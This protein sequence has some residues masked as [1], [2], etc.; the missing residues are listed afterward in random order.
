MLTLLT[1]ILSTPVSA[2]A[3]GQPV[4][5]T[6]RVRCLEA[7]ASAAD[8]A[9]HPCNAIGARF[10]FDTADGRQV[11]LLDDDPK[12]GA[13]LDPV[14]RSRA[15]LL[16]GWERGIDGFEILSVFSVL[17]GRKHHVHYRCDVCDITASGPGPCWCCGA[18][19]ER[20]EVAVDT[21]EE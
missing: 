21:H 8:P 1:C 16:R 6:G 18:D 14:V 9:D 3:E 10:M 5:L 4:E 17:D 11:S 2:A 7:E 13:F 20:R 12:A 19:F 15:L